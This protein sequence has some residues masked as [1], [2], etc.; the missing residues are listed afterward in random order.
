[1]KKKMISCDLSQIEPR[2]L[3]WCAGDEDMLYLM[4]QGQSPYEAHA[5]A[6]MQWT[7]TG[8]EL[9][10]DKPFYGLAKVRVLG[11]GYGCGWRKFIKVAAD[12]V[13]LDITKDDPKWVDMEGQP[14]ADNDDST[15]RVSGYGLNSKRIV[16]E[17]REQNPL[18]ASREEGPDCLPIGLWHRL[19][20]AF[21]SSIGEDFEMV[22]PSGRTMLYRDVRE[23][24]TMKENE[25]TG[26]MERR[27]AVTAEGFRN[28]VPVR[29]NLYGGLL[30]ENLVQAT[31][32]DVFAEHLLM[33]EDMPGVT[34]LFTCHDEAV[35]EVDENISAKDIEKVMSTCPSWLKGCPIAAEAKEIPCYCK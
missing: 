4:A 13:G 18:L 25:D 26:K 12:M 3:A 31:A 33:L 19:D 9:K 11:L 1:M 16:R 29:L 20:L 22:L 17:F 14:L 10:A 27:R 23:A 6:T 21:R 32:R 5:R 2:I 7:G 35:L 15:V 34:I 30:T 8:K 24:W 28:G